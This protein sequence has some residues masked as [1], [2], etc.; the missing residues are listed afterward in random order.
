MAHR[1][2]RALKGLWAFGVWADANLKGVCL[3]A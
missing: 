1:A 2:S 3:K